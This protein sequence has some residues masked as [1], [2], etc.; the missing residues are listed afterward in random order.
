[1]WDTDRQRSAE[2]RAK[3][4]RAQAQAIQQRAGTTA[5]DSAQ[6]RDRADVLAR[7]AE[8]V[9]EESRRVKRGEVASGE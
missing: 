5:K 3:E 8:A 4:T 1:L 7:E 9:I 6:L 2:V